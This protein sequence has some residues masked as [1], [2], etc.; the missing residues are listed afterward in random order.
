MKTKTQVSTSFM[1]SKLT[2]GLL[3]YLGVSNKTKHGIYQTKIIPVIL[4]HSSY[5]FRQSIVSMSR[6]VKWET[7]A[8]MLLKRTT[9]YCHE[10]M[11]SL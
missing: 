5:Y 3:L 2:H 4:V 9:I 11:S 10:E 6:T 7:A 1:L 8:Q